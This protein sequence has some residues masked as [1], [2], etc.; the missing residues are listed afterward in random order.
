MRFRTG[1]GLV[2]L[3]GLAGVVLERERRVQRATNQ[4]QRR[5]V[6]LATTVARERA[7]DPAPFVGTND[8]LLAV[9]I[10][11]YREADSICD[12]LA[13]LPAMLEGLRVL[14]IVVDDGGGDATAEVARA[15]GAY[16]VQHPVNLGQGEALRT[17]FAVALDLGAEIVVTMDADGQHRPDELVT[18]VKPVVVGDA[19]YV[20]GSRFLGEYD[21]AGGMRHKGIEI[22]TRL[23]N[24]VSGAGITD[25]TNGYRAIRAT[26]LSRLTLVES[27]FNAPELIIESARHGLR[28]QEVPV[29]IRSREFGESKKPKGLGY[30]LGFLRVIVQTRF[31]REA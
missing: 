24:L 13:E 30:P 20:Q 27:R 10:P 25:C 15:A 16:V 19:D 31:R 4:W 26:G 17:G 2:A 28:I 7:E 22:F 18:L 3:G 5:L 11:A 21:D 8:P 29:H 14:P 1:L 9:V 23:I 12:V 6:T